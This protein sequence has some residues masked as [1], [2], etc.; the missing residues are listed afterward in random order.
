MNT[1]AQ[2]NL[3]DCGLFAI[4]NATEIAFGYNPSKCVLDLQNPRSHLIKCLEAGEMEHFP[5]VK[6]R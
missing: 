3:F 2:T 4:T 5:V 6:E 1:M